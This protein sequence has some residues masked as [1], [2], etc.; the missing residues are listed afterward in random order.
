MPPE[1]LRPVQAG[2]GTEG[3]ITSELLAER[4]LCP[5]GPDGRPRYR[6]ALSGR[7]ARRVVPQRFAPLSLYGDKGVFYGITAS[8]GKSIR[9]GIFLQVK[10]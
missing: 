10:V 3:N 2:G 9:R 7:Q 4:Q 8:F 5:V 1:S 6:A